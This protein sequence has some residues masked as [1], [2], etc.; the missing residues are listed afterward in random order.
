[1]VLFFN[2]LVLSSLEDR[3]GGF[4][5]SGQGE[6]EEAMA[7][8]IQGF[9]NFAV[10]LGVFTALVLVGYAA[11]I[12]VTSAGDQE[13]LKEAREVATNAII[14]AVMIA[15]GVIVLSVLDRALGTNIGS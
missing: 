9:L 8:F 1:M 4:M 11:F 12:M 15:L 2:N 5:E 3:L 6:G 13:K 14:G 7:G 10:P